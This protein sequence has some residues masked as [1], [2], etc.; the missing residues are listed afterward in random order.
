[1]TVDKVYRTTEFQD[2]ANAVQRAI[3][4]AMAG[5]RIVHVGKEPA[6]TWQE[7]TDVV[8]MLHKLGYRV[9]YVGNEP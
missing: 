5:F 7:A 6:C 1:M 8:K 2:A 3:T 9:V 4:D